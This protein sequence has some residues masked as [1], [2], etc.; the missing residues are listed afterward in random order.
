M[1]VDKCI[2]CDKELGVIGDVDESYNVLILNRGQTYFDFCS[3]CGETETLT[4]ETTGEVLTF[5]QVYN[6]NS[7]K[8]VRT[9]VLTN[10]F[11]QTAMEI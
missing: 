5:N 3:K 1:S 10:L 6:K 2:S 8:A 4:N 11:K 9:E 7:R